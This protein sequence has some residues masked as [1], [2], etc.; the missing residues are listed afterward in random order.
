MPILPVEAIRP[1]ATTE[2]DAA[3][4]AAA[5]DKL[6][7]LHRKAAFVQ[8]KCPA[9]GGA[10]FSQ[11]LEKDGFLFGRCADCK[12]LYMP[13]RPSADMLAEFYSDSALMRHFSKNIFPASR[14]ARTRHIYQPR[15]EMLLQH[16]NNHQQ[17]PERERTYAEI[18]AGSGLFAHLVHESQAFDRVVA[19]EP[20]AALAADCRA[21]GLEVFECPVEHLDNNMHIDVA[22]SFEVIEHLFSPADFIEHMYRILA[23]N[24][25]CILTTPNGLGLDVLE[26]G[27]ASTTVGF[28][29]LTLLNPDSITRLMREK[30]F[31]ILEVTTP[32][33]LDVS[34]VREGWD[35]GVPPA[36]PFLYY[37]LR[38]ASQSIAEAFQQF[39]CVNLLSSHMWIVAQKK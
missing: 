39:L 3:K 12:T 9:C 20:A 19:V 27:I 18:G 36:S 21:C 13:M 37:M 14:E 10:S 1:K 26:L 11:Q 2:S 35:A 30:G 6:W 16:V 31:H 5:R 28:T 8:V 23:P 24:G 15:L 22:A 29:H 7:L 25:L 33:K 32:G 38:E 17:S 34:L 4:E